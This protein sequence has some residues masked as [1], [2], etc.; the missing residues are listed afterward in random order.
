MDLQLE[1]RKLISSEMER[2]RALNPNFSLR[3]LSKKL[4]LQPSALSEILSGKRLITRRM[5]ARVLERLCVDP[6]SGARI[7]GGLANRVSNRST[8]T[9]HVDHKEYL[10]LNMDHYHVI[11][12]WYYFAIISLAETRSFR[13]DPQWIARRLNIKLAEASMALER[14]ERL[15]LLARTKSG[16]LKATGQQ[17][18]TSTDIAN[19]SLRKSHNQ[20]LELARRS[21]NEDAVE[22]RDFSSMTMAIDPARLLEAKKMIKEFRRK[23]CTY[24]ER[25]RKEEVY[26]ICIQLFPLSRQGEDV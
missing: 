25:G 15:G 4:G 1:V 5:A 2:A 19:M 21:L 6:A 8:Q 20:N 17:F 23:F 12:E 7:L 26:R 18:A 11:S 22:T 3:A 9:E 14:L 10:Q 16:K 13:D 24:M